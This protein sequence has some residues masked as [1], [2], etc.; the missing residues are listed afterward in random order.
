MTALPTG[1]RQDVLALDGEPD[2]DP[3]R[4][5]GPPG[6]EHPGQ[7]RLDRVEVVNWGTFDGHH[8]VD[9]ARSGFLLTGH[10]GS[11]KSSLLDAVAAVLTPRGRLR[12][13]AAAADAGQQGQDRTVA[14]YVR[15]AWSRQADELTGEVVSQHL[16]TGATWSGILLRYADGTARPPVHL[17]KLLHM[18]RSAATASEVSDQ[19]LL[20]TTP[21]GL[22]DLAP[23]AANGLEARRLKQAYP[24]AT[25]T[26]R[27][28]VFAARF[29]RLLGM[30]GDNALEL[31]HRTQAAKNLGSLDELFRGYMLDE[32]ATFRLAE[33]AVE[34]FAELS[35]AHA[36]VVEARD[37]VAHLA[38]LEALSAGYD[39]AEHALR[40]AETLRDVLPVVTDAW[41]RRLVEEESERTRSALEIADADRVRAEVERALADRA[42]LGAEAALDERGGRAVREAADAVATAEGSLRQVAAS[43]LEVAA[44]LEAVGVAMPGTAAEWAELRAQAARERAELATGATARRERLRDAYGAD[45]TA[46]GEVH[47]LER[48]LD[49]LRRVRSNLDAGLIDARRRVAAAAGIGERELPFAGELLQVRPEHA[50]WA[51]AIERALRPL[52]VVLLVPAVHRHAVV[53]A[54]DATHLGA[55]LRLEVVAPDVAGPPRSVGERSLVRRVEVRPGAFAPWLGSTLSRTYDLECV[56]QVADLHLVD[57][58]LTR[59]GQVKRGPRS[60]DKDDRRRVDDREGW[61]LGWDN[62]DK[63]EHL[64]GL[65]RTAQGVAA[66]AAEAARRAQGDDEAAVRREQTLSVVEQRPW[67]ELDVS[68]AESRLEAARRAH[69][70]LLAASEDLRAAQHALAQ[71]QDEARRA[72]KVQ[73]ETQQRVSDLRGELRTLSRRHEGLADADDAHVAPEV[74]DELHRRYRERRRALTSENLSDV[75]MQV[76][77]ALENER[78]AALERRAQAEQQIVALQGSF[79]D[80]WR[81][82]AGDLTGHVDDRPGYLDVLRRLRADRLPEFETRFFEL[83]GRQSQR[84]VGVL[85]QTVLRALGEIRDRI[86]P[87]NRSLRRSAFDRGR[88]LQIRP[89]ESRTPAVVDFLADLRTISEGSW[90]PEDRV[91]A[92]ARFAVMARLMRRLQSSDAAD[93][94]WRAQ[95]LDTRRHVTFVGLEVDEEG[96]VLNVHDSAAGLSGGQRQ[97]L[98]VFC[99]AAALRYQLAGDDE[100]VP[101]YGTVVL[102]EAF[103]KADSRFTAMAMDVFLEFGF[104]MVLATPLKLLQTLEEYVGGIGLVTCTDFRASHVGLVGVRDGQLVD[105][106]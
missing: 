66:R 104:H 94:A 76:Q 78:A 24:D 77:R 88:Y 3:G 48:E 21:L 87:V 42:V 67:D 72:R 9:V 63:V 10:S 46:A 80:R 69:A 12:F 96:T 98:V 19:H 75:G 53:A 13:N 102:D 71:A 93:R 54:V 95:C 6:P 82:L 30:R 15:G 1:G 56:E 17:V 65:L 84:N 97:K 37:Q 4:E 91:A 26:D 33:T 8:V 31:L 41:R 27:H 70:R 101:G 35:Q 20:T 22:L 40:H 5:V 49:V 47:R 34:Q 25:V 52:A 23:Y 74:R 83:L 39:E 59:A 51:G 100:A 43:R 11:G 44:A 105:A 99:L 79:R 14:S 16:R 7:W 57:R 29:T 90:A 55:R 73:D 32:P 18:R 92:E 85:R 81:G 45:S 86:D 61:V 36:A 50:A 60:F 103:D 89:Q 38:P 62:A 2:D 106:G 58:G 64:L 68:A 28:S